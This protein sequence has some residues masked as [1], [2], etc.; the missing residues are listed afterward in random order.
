MTG[1][2]Q[3]SPGVEEVPAMYAETLIL[4]AIL[5]TA[6]FPIN[7]SFRQPG[8][9]LRRSS[10]LACVSALSPGCIA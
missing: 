6:Q 5:K 2:Q 3:C 8:H 7:T 1:M 4:I 9:V 10:L